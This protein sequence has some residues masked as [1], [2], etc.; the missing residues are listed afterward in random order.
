MWCSIARVIWYITRWIWLSCILVAVTNYLVSVILLPA[1]GFTNNFSS[2]AFGYLLLGPYR[3]LIFSLIGGFAGITFVSWFIT[4]RCKKN[5]KNEPVFHI[6]LI[7]QGNHIDVLPA[8]EAKKGSF[9]RVTVFGSSSQDMSTTSPD[10]AE[11]EL[12]AYPVLVSANPMLDYVRWLYKSIRQ[13][14]LLR[15]IDPQYSDQHLSQE[16][17]T[18]DKIYIPIN[19][20]HLVVRDDD[21]NIV[22]QEE[23]KKEFNEDVFAEKRTALTVMEVLNLTP[24]LVLLG[25]PGSGKSTFINFVALCMLGPHLFPSTDWLTILKEQ[26]WQQGIYLPILVNLRDFA[27]NIR[28]VTRQGDTQILWKSI[29]L[30]LHQHNCSSTVPILQEA[31]EKGHAFVLLD[32][33][34]EVPSQHRT[35]IREAIIEFIEN[36]HAENR[37]LITCRIFSYTDE[38]WRIPQTIE[39]TIA[40]FDQDQ[41]AHFIQ[42]WYAALAATGNI[43]AG[44]VQSLTK[45]LIQRLQHPELAELASN[46]MLL[47]IIAM[48]H[49][50]TGT[51]PRERARL[52]AL[53]VQLLLIRW[54]GQEVNSLIERLGVREDDLY[55][56]LWE[57][58]YD[59]HKKQSDILVATNISEA[60]I[61]AIARKRLGDLSKAQDFCEY[62]E[63]RAGLLIG[64]G[65]DAKGWRMFAF[66]HRSFQEYLAGCYI[67]SNRFTRQAPRLVQASV[68]WRGPLLL[69]TGHLVFNQGDITTPLDAIK[70]LISTGVPR[71]NADWFA[72]WLA[73]DMLLLVGKENVQ[74]DEVGQEVLPHTQRLLTQLIDRGELSP[75]IRAAL[76][77]TSAELGDLRPGVG[78]NTTGLPDLVFCEVPA[79]PFLMGSDRKEEPEAT[80]REIPKHLNTSL[81]WSFFLARYLVTNMQFQSFV[82]A[83]DGYRDDQNWTRAGLS[84]RNKQGAFVFKY[85]GTFNL[86]NHPVVGITWYEASA[87][88]Q[89][90]TRQFH[91]LGQLRVW[92]SGVLEEVPFERISFRLPDEVAWEK[93][94]RGTDGRRY[95]WGNDFSDH[96]CNS[97]ETLLS[98]TSAVG[99]FPSGASPYGLLDMCGNVWEWCQNTWG[100]MYQVAFDANSNDPEGSVQRV[101]RGGGYDNHRWLV[102]AACRFGNVPAF[103]L[104]DLGFRVY[105]ETF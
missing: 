12:P 1:Q 24:R 53:C 55:R 82:E 44:L 63:K 79:G 70:I 88:C 62:I 78:V 105:A 99:I 90:L 54:K 91:A 20:M 73:S 28:L 38:A 26:G 43:K 5:E 13:S 46:P 50:H 16:Q 87:F 65:Q 85:G 104:D 48:V 67:A 42:T 72:V 49:N 31:L 18:V 77:R 103:S 84:W 92:R 61:V 45:D 47:T 10:K 97:K 34:D 94:A 25:A 40:P 66:P 52:Y 33:L 81:R 29:I 27:H 96:Y 80:A 76:A 4:L 14:G 15:I 71:N 3:T 58:A 74:K 7:H 56:I 21:G 2:S 41:I 11:Q 59:A 17:I 60:D 35:S 95:A 68:Q 8:D 36:G 39:E 75:L 86:A 69:A 98:S 57:I 89:W 19:T 64:M 32:G 22:D 23:Y 102:R 93:A 83:R 9:S 37:Y 101:L 100:W 51:L 6:N 30:S